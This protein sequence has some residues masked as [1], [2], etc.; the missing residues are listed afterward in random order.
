MSCCT[1]W[2]RVLT[3]ESGC[4]KSELCTR[5]SRRCSL[6]LFNVPCLYSYPSL[7][8]SAP[9]Y[10]SRP[11]LINGKKFHLR[12]YSL[13]LGALQVHVFS[14]IL[15][16]IAAHKYNMDDLGNI[17]QHLTNTARSV[18]DDT[19]VEEENVKLMDDLPALLWE[20]YRVDLPGGFVTCLEHAQEI[21]RDILDQVCK[22]TS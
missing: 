2:R 9:R 5:I 21:T 20:E 22:I 14:K 7:F 3:S 8:C 1:V 4:F 6:C 18:E 19:F 17:Y 10:I 15:M 12:V 16:L 13:C 11:L